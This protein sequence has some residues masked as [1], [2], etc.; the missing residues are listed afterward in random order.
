MI[1][2]SAH[3]IARLF[4]GL[5][6]STVLFYVGGA[7]SS[8]GPIVAPVLRSMTSKSVALSE[9]GKVFAL[10][11]VFDNAIPIF[12]GTLYSQIYIA[13]VDHHPAAIFWLTLCTQVLV[14]LM[15]L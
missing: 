12:S 9:R 4:F 8:L 13:T 6:T 10:L 2:A 5:A 1:G 11:S 3:A 14:F 7:V 15:I